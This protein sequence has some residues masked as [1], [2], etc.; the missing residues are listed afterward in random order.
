[1]S[2]RRLHEAAKAGNAM[3]VK[4]YLRTESVNER[5]EYQQTP[6]HVACQGNFVDIVK[7]LLKKKADVNP[8]D[9]N[10][11]TPLHCGAS[12]G[13]LDVL[14]LLLTC[15][16]IDV[17][18]LNKDGTS[19]LHYL[20]RLTVPSSKLDLYL[21]VLELFVK[22][23]GDLNS[24]TKHGEGAL[25]Q[26]CLRGN[27]PAVKFLLEHEANI[28]L[29]NKMGETGLHYAVRAGQKEIIDLLIRYGADVTLKSED[30]TPLDLSPNAEITRFIE[31]AIAS[32][33]EGI[34]IIELSDWK[35]KVRVIRAQALGHAPR[36]PAAEKEPSPFCQLSFGKQRVTT[37]VKQ[38][39]AAPKWGEEFFFDIEDLSAPVKAQVFHQEGDQRATR[40]DMLGSMTLNLA[41]FPELD[42]T[43][44]P[45]EPLLQW[46]PLKRGK[47]KKARLRLELSF[48]SADAVQDASAVQVPQSSEPEPDAAALQQGTFGWKRG[49]CK[50][51]DCDCER[52]Q[53]ESG[54][55][56]PCQNCG[57]FPARHL[58]L[59][60]ASGGEGSIPSPRPGSPAGGAEAEGGG[61]PSNTPIE[62]QTMEDIER[63]LKNASILGDG[64]SANVWELDAKEL[65]LTDQLGEGT[66]AKVFSGKYRGQHVAIKVLKEKS[67]DKVLAEFKKEFDIMSSLRSPHVVFFY[68]A[69]IQPSLCMVL[70]FC[71]RGS[72]HDVLSDLQ[73]DITWARVLRA[74]VDTMKGLTCL[75]Y[76]KPVI[77]H[78]DL[79]TLNLLV[80]ENYLVK[81]SDFGLSRFSSGGEADKNQETL[82]KLR[83]TYA[84]CAPE[85]YFG[86]LY[87]PAAD[88]FS[89]GVI[90]WEMAYRCIY[91]EYQQPY[92]EYKNI[93][94]DFQ[95]IIQTAKKGVRPTIPPGTPAT[96]R[97][98]IEQCWDEEPKNR[99][100]T[101][102]LMMSVQELVKEY[103]AD[104]AAWDAA[105]VPPGATATATTSGDGAAADAP[106]AG[107]AA[108]PAPGTGGED[109]E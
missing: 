52:Y 22:R 7:Q 56:G 37:K 82:G 99:P 100:E 49:A 25:H 88:I 28:N 10:G 105:I 26:A 86:Q 50:E 38:H 72:L 67:D 41:D 93:V 18:V 3:E 43:K 106:G 98:L 66:S 9:R 96:Y 101:S 74:A 21:R 102:D 27:A 32:R 94:F 23:R 60:A 42:L 71:H 54:K 20:V 34:P 64:T 40:E 2:N 11:W 12:Y 55:G 75:H 46:F 45:E 30:G 73:E 5:D 53:A 77:V 4:R 1:M 89:M 90:L 15:D 33:G 104:P 39:T 80:D 29:L 76:W 87:S 44:R 83:G 107:D 48:V 35:L 81:V 47:S 78:R 61:G 84:Y 103:E 92:A 36:D 69:C 14:E 68:G 17:G 108:E 65:Q 91:R 95:I 62:D 6:L 59:G 8:Q 109:G 16:D 97:K 13:S 79:K 24:Q 85:V 19:A 31:D 57:H 63:N 70:E 51:A 58:K